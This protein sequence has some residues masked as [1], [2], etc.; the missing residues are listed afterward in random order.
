MRRA[1]LTHRIGLLTVAFVLMIVAGH[2]ETLLHS[3]T[4]ATIYGLFLLRHWRGAVA[5]V[6]AG[7]VALLLTAVVL[8]W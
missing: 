6:V 8:V 4:M 5:V 3:V 2:P 1:V 7:V